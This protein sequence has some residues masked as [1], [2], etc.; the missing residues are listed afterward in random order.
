MHDS[1]YSDAPQDDQPHGDDEL[2]ML[3]LAVGVLDRMTPDQLSRT[4]TY[5]EARFGTPATGKRGK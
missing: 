5:L 2:A 4:M 3:S 1:P